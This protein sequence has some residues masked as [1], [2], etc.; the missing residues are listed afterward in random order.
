M[1]GLANYRARFTK[2]LREH[3]TAFTLY[4]V[5]GSM[6]FFFRRYPSTAVLVLRSLTKGFV[7]SLLGPDYWL[8]YYWPF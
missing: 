6:R 4:T 2:S 1:H 8:G 3:P 5:S 7:W